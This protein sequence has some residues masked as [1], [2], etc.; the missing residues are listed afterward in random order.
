MVRHLSAGEQKRTL[1]KYEQRALDPANIEKLSTQGACL[2]Q[3]KSCVQHV[4]QSQVILLREAFHKATDQEKAG[5]FQFMNEEAGNPSR[6]PGH[7]TE[8]RVFGKPVCADGFQKLLGIGG[9]GG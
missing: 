6:M 4:R 8:W 3:G 5:F 2:C 9:A 7:R 1:N